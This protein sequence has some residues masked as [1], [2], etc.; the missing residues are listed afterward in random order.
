[1]LADEKKLRPDQPMSTRRIGA[2]IERIRKRHWRTGLTA[3]GSDS[4]N[5][6][7]ALAPEDYS[8]SPAALSSP[9]AAAGRRR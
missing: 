4:H 7:K 8:R 3:N 9:L 6:S 5:E 2:E 1:M